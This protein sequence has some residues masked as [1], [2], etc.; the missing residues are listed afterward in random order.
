MVKKHECD[1]CGASMLQFGNFVV[2]SGLLI[3]IAV[4]FVCG[5]VITVMMC[6]LMR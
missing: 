1:E 4:G 2:D 3:G 6:F 5:A